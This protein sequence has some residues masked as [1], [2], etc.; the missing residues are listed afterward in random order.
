MLTSGD[1]VDIDLGVP[2]GHEAGFPRPAVVVTAQEVL[3]RRPSVVHVIPLTTTLRDFSC[4]VT[5]DSGLS[6]LTTTSSAQCQHIRAISAQRLS[7]VRGNIGPQALM[8]VRE[9]VAVLLDL[10]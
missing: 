6:G 1:V 7:S 4:E 9:T 3:D 5:I 8:S 10:P 2:T